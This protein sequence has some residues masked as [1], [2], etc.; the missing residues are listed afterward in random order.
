MLRHAFE[1]LRFCMRPRRRLLAL[2]AGVVICF[3]ILELLSP[4]V[5]QLYVD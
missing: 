4:K 1:L 3:N 5:L 2:T